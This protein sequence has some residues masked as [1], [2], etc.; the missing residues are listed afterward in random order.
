MREHEVNKLE[1]FIV[2]YYIDGDSTW[3][4]LIE[5]FNAPDADRREGITGTSSIDK[6]VKDST[7]V[8]LHPGSDLSYS[9]FET[10]KPAIT[11]YVEKY[12]F[13]RHASALDIV[14]GSTIQKYDAQHGGF[15][16]WHY[17]NMGDDNVTS[18]RAFVFMTY[19]NDVEEG[20]ETEF[21]YQK[22]KIKPEKG[23][24]VMFPAYWTHVH[25]GLKSSSEKYI[26]TGWFHFTGAL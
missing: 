23:L 8:F 25:R 14:E 21:L 9:Y 19:L 18:R 26:I 16:K 7:D 11:S 12:S 6:T 13:L 24:T 10:V 2:G 22:Y 1:N 4:S 17:E 3:N 15:H 5:F 20:G